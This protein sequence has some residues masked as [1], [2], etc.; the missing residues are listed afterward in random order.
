LT[1]II[2]SDLQWTGGSNATG[3]EQFHDS[4]RLSPVGNTALLRGQRTVALAGPAA[5]GFLPKPP[6]WHIP[7][8]LTLTKQAWLS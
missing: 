8:T 7:E 2:L 4:R 5:W 6:F 3:G 1:S